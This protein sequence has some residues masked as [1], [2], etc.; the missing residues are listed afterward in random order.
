L[1]LPES[2]I[3]PILYR[4]FDKQ[5]IVYDSRVVT[6]QREKVMQNMFADNFGL[7]TA[8]SNKSPEPDHFFC[9][10]SMMEAK[11]AESTTQSAIFPLYLYP[12]QSTLAFDDNERR[13]NLSAEF[14]KALGTTLDL[15]LEGEYS[16]PRGVTPEEIFGYAYAVFHAPSYCEKYASFLKTDFLRLP[17][18]VNVESFRALAKLGNKLVALHLLDEKSAPILTEARHAFEGIGS[19]VAERAEYSETAR[20]VW[21]NDAQRFENVPQSVWE[22]RIGGYAP[23]QKWLKDRKGRV[24][25]FEEISHYARVL[26]ALDE[27]RAFMSEIDARLAI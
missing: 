26:I 17:L 27:T 10:R 3:K 9:T 25:S 16:L 11:C 8:R 22:F 5:F 2:V 23:A 7:A 20:Q 21:I 18:P 4:P 13:P 15:P 1:D 14:L 24:L 6:R 19:R 12:E